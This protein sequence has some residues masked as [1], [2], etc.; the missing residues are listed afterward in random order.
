[1]MLLTPSVRKRTGNAGSIL[2]AHCSFGGTKSASSGTLY[3]HSPRFG[4]GSFA[5]AGGP[6]PS[7]CAQ[8]GAALDQTLPIGGTG[9]TAKCNPLGQREV[10]LS[11]RAADLVG[12]LD[13]LANPLSF[14]LTYSSTG[15]CDS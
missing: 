9:W 15:R 8:Y 6:Y 12:L 5:G 11:A 14:G 13:G 3:D 4:K 1:M 7:F 2:A 10:S